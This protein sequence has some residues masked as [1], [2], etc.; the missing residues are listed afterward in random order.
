MITR[1]IAPLLLGL[2][3]FFVTADAWAGSYLNRAA[4]LLDGAR[5]DRDMV[6][7]RAK[8]KELVRMVH[9]IAQVRTRVAR[10][11]KVPASVAAAHPHL[12][13]V[14]E[15]CERAYDA[16]LKGKMEKFVRH[17]VRARAEDRTF[18]AIVVKLGYTMPKT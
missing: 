9:Q 17:I 1:I 2:S 13:L 14:L 5:A 4:L 11:M 10:N 6:R 12:L 7:P 18:R 8:D 15:N 16:A 3:L